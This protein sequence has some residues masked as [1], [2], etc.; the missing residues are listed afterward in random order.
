LTFLLVT[1]Y[2][3]DAPPFPGQM[4][5]L[6]NEKTLFICMIPDS[7]PPGKEFQG[8]IVVP[9]DSQTKKYSGTLLGQPQ[10]PKYPAGSALFTE[11]VK[12]DPTVAVAGKPQLKPMDPTTLTEAQSAP[13]PGDPNPE[14]H[15]TY[16]E[17]T[18]GTQIFIPDRGISGYLVLQN[19][20]PYDP[21]AIKLK[22]T[23]TPKIDD[24]G[25]KFDT[26]TSAEVPE[27][28]AS[29]AGAMEINAHFY[30]GK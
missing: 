3:N 11:A 30:P 27:Y 18:K 15:G 9:V 1:F 6:E 7:T 24:V 5:K 8:T 26:D 14:F 22:G 23:F 25:E 19:G 17:S 21:L 13:N 10:N 4:E 16:Y 2:P 12:P 28:I 29:L 20:L